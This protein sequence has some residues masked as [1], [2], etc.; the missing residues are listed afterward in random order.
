MNLFV[1]AGRSDNL[2]VDELLAPAT[3]GV[4]FGGRTVP[5]RGLVIDAPTAVAQPALRQAAQ[6]AGLPLIVDPLTHLIQDEQV[7]NKGWAAL[8]FADP[9]AFSADHFFDDSTLV[10]LVQNRSPFNSTRA[11]RSWCPRTSTRNLRP[12]RGFG[13]SSRPTG[14]PRSTSQENELTFQ[15]RQ[16]SLAA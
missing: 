6:G 12:I 1:R 3:A 15:S 8:N 10:P 16:S 2:V 11:R 13:F 14:K 9:H 7:P 5:M 4:P